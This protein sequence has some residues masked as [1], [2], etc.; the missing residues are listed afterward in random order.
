MKTARVED[1]WLWLS[2]ACDRAREG[3]IRLVKEAVVQ[4]AEIC[5][6]WVSYQLVYKLISRAASH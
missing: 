6:F 2:E 5:A 1:V 3:G 4:V